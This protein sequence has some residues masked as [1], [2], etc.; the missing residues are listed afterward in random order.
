MKRSV[1]AL[2]AALA[3]G[4]FW[5]AP[6][7]AQTPLSTAFSYQGLLKENGSAANG[8]YDFRFRLFDAA[9]LGNQVGA[10]VFVN[11]LTVTDGTFT[12]ELNFGAQFDGQARW[13]E[14]AVRPGASPGAYT[15]LNPR[16]SLTAAPYALY[17]L[18]GLWTASGTSISNS[19]SGFVGVGRSTQVTSAE[20]FGI[21]SPATGTSYGGMYIRTDGDQAKPFYGYRAATGSACWTYLD[22]ATGSWH[23]YNGADRLTVT[24]NGDVGIGDATPDA[25]LSV[26]ESGG[27]DALFVTQTG[28]SGRAAQFYVPGTSPASAIYCVTYGGGYAGSFEAHSPNTTAALNCY[29]NGGP[30]LR[31]WSTLSTAGTPATDCAMAVVGGTDTSQSGGGFLVLGGVNATNLSIDNNELQARNN[32]AASTLYLNNDAGNVVIA[33][34]GTATV[35]VLEVTGADV[36]E[37]FPVSEEVG[38]G[39]VV[40]IDAAN[41]GKLCA[42]RGAYNKRVAGVVSGAN[43]LPAGTVLGNLPGH[44]NSPPIALSGRVWVLC[45]A[46]TGAIGVGDLLTTSDTPGHAMAAADPARSHGAVIG[47][48]MTMLAKGERGLVLVLINL[49]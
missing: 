17:A 41:P 36:A 32:G 48:A 15:A 19:N 3:S 23:V 13:M 10:D 24:N 20:K 21:Q 49:Q 35:R 31:V 16:Q 25:R 39:M 33:P 14:I 30:A 34:N 9:A 7:A 43:D 1:F 27:G 18:G 12:A 8:V 6:A 42:A 44:E 28:A 22:G 38:P 46:T 5:V 37:K 47:K 2:V 26:A 11:D 45:D 29:K 4:L 40:M